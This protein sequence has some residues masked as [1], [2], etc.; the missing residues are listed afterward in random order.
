MTYSSG[1]PI[2][3]AG[4]RLALDLVNTADWASD[5][6]VADEKLVTVEDVRLW[7]DA[8]GLPRTVQPGSVG[9][10]RELR[11]AVRNLLAREG[12]AGRAA[13]IVSEALQGANW[14]SALRDARNASGQ[15]V[16]LTVA[17]LV[18]VSAV[19]IL[20]DERE[21]SRVKLCPGHD[22]GWL[23]LDETRNGR[24]RWCLME[25]CGNRAKARRNY[26][27]RREVTG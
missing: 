1:S 8:L 2:R 11:V 6:T 25:T 24:R 20:S 13:E 12:D 21:I 3:L 10:L 15:A 22:C 26:A 27:R 18:A 19:S 17:Q 16:S 4:G 7:T 9:Q 14:K 5:G 23:F